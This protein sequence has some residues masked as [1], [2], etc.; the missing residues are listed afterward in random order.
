MSAAA[1]RVANYPVLEIKRV[2]N[3]SPERVF[4]AWTVREEWQAWIGPEGIHCDVTRLDARAGGRYELTMH[5]PDGQSRQIGGEFTI[6]DRPHTLA[7]TWGACGTDQQTLVILSFRDL[8]NGR[9]ELTLRHEG[10]P[11]EQIRLDHDKGWSSTL[12]K[13]AAYLG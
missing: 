10:L 13:L 11:S 2:F 4:A 1:Q 7:F 9:T 3:A 12:G 5:F 6:V 8:G